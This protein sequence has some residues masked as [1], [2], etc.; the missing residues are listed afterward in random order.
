MAT[1]SARSVTSSPGR[2]PLGKPAGSQPVLVRS[3][4]APVAVRS[5][6]SAAPSEF[7]AAAAVAGTPV[8]KRN[9]SDGV[10]VSIDGG[11]I[12]PIVRNAEAKPLSA[13]SNEMKDLAA[14]AK[15]KKDQKPLNLQRPPRKAGDKPWW[16]RFYTN[17]AKVKDREL[18]A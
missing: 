4:T 11:L 3:T 17:R 2:R 12:T 14:R 7:C 10:A 13:I 16:D 9:I 6:H 15:A 18:F 1:R 8:F 5:T